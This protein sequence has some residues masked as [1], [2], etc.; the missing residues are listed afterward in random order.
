MTMLQQLKT[1]AR[2]VH[3]LR[4]LAL[5]TCMVLLALTAGGMLM[6]PPRSPQPLAF[7]FFGAACWALVG[8]RLLLVQRAMQQFR[9]PHVRHSVGLALGLLAMLTVVLPALVMA[10]A[11]GLTIEALA[12]LILCNLAGLVYALAPIWVVIAVGITPALLTFAASAHVLAALHLPAQPLAPFVV[13]M[14]LAAAGYGLWLWRAWLVREPS[15]FN[16]VYVPWV[17]R[18]GDQPGFASGVT[19]KR[20]LQERDG[21]STQRTRLLQFDLSCPASTI[22]YFLGRPYAFVSKRELGATV[23]V[24]LFFGLGSVL[25]GWLLHWSTQGMGLT[26]A[27]MAMMLLPLP[28]ADAMLSLRLKSYGNFLTELALL[29]GLG[30]PRTAR[31]HVLRAML[32]R[33]QRRFALMAFA[34][35]LGTLLLG[36]PPRLLVLMF[37]LTALAFVGNVAA[38]VNIMAMRHDAS[39]LHRVLEPLGW[40]LAIALIMFTGI[41]AVN[42]HAAAGS[43]INRAIILVL[44]IGWAIAIA[45]L[46]TRLA[47]DWRRF[48]R[49]PHPFLQR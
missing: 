48:Q 43:G 49:R 6:W 28:T 1:A 3:A 8:S 20:A 47:F 23:A 14:M 9:M 26:L 27:G 24:L 33:G 46:L 35:M 15:D 45:A 22:R 40:F 2:M 11:G 13:L 16:S 34:L 31:R 37:A 38:I 39:R 30:T 4:P 12:L 32:G 36:A 19:I 21:R 29:P 5:Y 42:Y 7:G 17:M 25:G 41:F 10:M 18:M 44:G